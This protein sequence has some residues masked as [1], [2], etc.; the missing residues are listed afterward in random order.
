MRLV[1]AGPKILSRPLR[2]QTIG[3]ACADLFWHRSIWCNVVAGGPR[4]S[5]TLKGFVSVQKFRVKTPPLEEKNLPGS[6]MSHLCKVSKVEK[7]LLS[8]GSQQERWPCKLIP[9]SWRSGLAQRKLAG[10]LMNEGERAEGTMLRR[11]A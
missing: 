9:R 2:W 4:I 8:L 11:K 6:L 5:I 7:E 3:V 1:A 10:A